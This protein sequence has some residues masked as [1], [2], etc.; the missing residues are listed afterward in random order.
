MS[1]RR[2]SCRSLS[3]LE[4]LGRAMNNKNCFHWVF[5]LLSK[6]S[7]RDI[8]LLVLATM[9]WPGHKKK[10]VITLFSQF[11]LLLFNVVSNNLLQL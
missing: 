7:V 9:M 11:V 3:V 1:D 5:V 10:I 4:G 2:S 8:K 6:I